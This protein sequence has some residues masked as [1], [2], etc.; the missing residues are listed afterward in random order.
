MEFS[1]VFSMK[2]KA[3]FKNKLIRMGYIPSAG[4]QQPSS[5]LRMR[6][7]IIRKNESLN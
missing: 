5:M 4:C 1:N 6:Y 3:E 2:S 7:F